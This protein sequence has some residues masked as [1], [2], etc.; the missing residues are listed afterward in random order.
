MPGRPIIADLSLAKRPA[1]PRADPNNYYVSLGLDPRESW[2]HQDIRTA[3][4]DQVKRYHPDGSEPDPVAYERVQLAYAVLG[5]EETRAKYDALDANTVWRD[6]E[7]VDAIIRRIAEGRLK[8]GQEKVDVAPLLKEALQRTEGPKAPPGPQYHSFAFY[9]YEDEGFPSEQVR[10]RW[11]ELVTQ[12]C[13]RIGKRNEIRLGFT[14]GEPHVVE[15][16]WGQ[17]MMVS[18]DPSIE[19]AYKLVE[20]LNDSRELSPQADS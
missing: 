17:V 14:Q 12:A 19:T 1:P 18:G 5:D 16:S 20:M 13:W 11:V 7:V 8:P 2:T 15:K 4:R 10:E 3:F 9:H 6:K